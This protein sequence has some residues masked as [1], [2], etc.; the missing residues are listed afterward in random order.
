MFDKALMSLFPASIS[1]IK[2]HVLLLW[3]G[4]LINISTTVLVVEILFSALEH[5]EI[6]IIKWGISGVFAIF[7]LFL[8]VIMKCYFT[9]KAG[10]EAFLSASKVKF[11][12]REKIYRKMI[13]L[14]G[15]PPEGVTTAEIMQILVEGVEQL[16]LYFSGYLPQL[17]YSLLAPATLFLVVSTMDVTAGL[18]LFFCVPLIPISII[19]VQ[20][21]AKKLFY[22]YWGDYTSLGQ[23]FLEN[24]Y[25]LTTLKI[26]QADGQ[27]AEEMSDSAEKFRKITMN[28]LSAQLNSII[29]MDIVAYGGAALGIIV[30]SRH[31]FQGLLSLQQATVILL[32][33][34]EF[35]LPMRRLGSFF[36]VSMNGMAASKKI[37]SLL[38]SAEPS[39]G[40]DLPQTPKASLFVENLSYHYPSGGGGVE[41]LTLTFPPCSMTAI[42]GESGSGKSTLAKLL[43][44]QCLY[45]EGELRLG[46][47]PL[48]EIQREAFAEIITYVPYNGYLFQGTVRENLL[49][50][51]ENATEKE[52]FSVLERVNLAEHFQ[53][54]QGLDT[55]LRSDGSNLSGG[56]RQRLTIARAF[57]H[58]SPIYIFDEVTSQIDGENEDHIMEEI[59]LLAENATVIFITHRL[60]NCIKGKN[61][62]VMEGGRCVQEGN[63]NDLLAEDGAY[64]NLWKKQ[65]AMTDYGEKNR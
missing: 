14:R 23:I 8:L 10:R 47:Q 59:A 20:K 48:E 9:M 38:G 7:P 2:K 41:A 35:F 50:A 27:K 16:E 54:H 43:T 11:V 15:I 26:F 6:Q 64:Q 63:H 37:F 60:A 5:R 49:L 17:F 19:I 45:Q 62:Y 53:K 29:V 25:G 57:L 61:I 32:L 40:D 18:I 46:A 39:S 44:K 24:L 33:S 56:Q 21:I 22:Q 3:L 12:L 1:H 52:L 55:K 34:G 30:A 31:L 13:S 28:V 36:H 58:Q 51:R 42:V 65:E 4:L